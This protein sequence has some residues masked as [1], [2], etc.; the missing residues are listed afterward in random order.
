MQQLPGGLIQDLYDLYQSC[1]AGSNKEKFISDL[2]EKEWLLLLRDKTSGR[3]VGFS[4]Q[5]IIRVVVENRLIRGIFSGDTI[6]DPNYWG[7]QELVRTWCQFAG[8]MKARFSDAPLFWFLISKGYR[9]YLY[10]PFFFKEFFPRYERSTPNFEKQLIEAF[11][12][13]KFPGRFNPMTG[14]IEP[15]GVRDYLKH[16]FDSALK[17]KNNLHVAYFIERNRSYSQGTELV[18]VA[19][20]EADNMRGIAKK[21]LEKGLN[22]VAPGGSRY[23]L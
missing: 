20:I 12:N 8:R 10:L 16:E 17:K 21:E 19:E 3:V 5:M 11:A 23:E 6:L 1:Y 13:A 2:S 15:N 18:C 9:T 22:S 14:L 7:E 4:T